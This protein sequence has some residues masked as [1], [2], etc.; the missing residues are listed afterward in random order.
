MLEA[1]VVG[2]WRLLAI[3]SELESEVRERSWLMTNF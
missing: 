3:L 2:V 1:F